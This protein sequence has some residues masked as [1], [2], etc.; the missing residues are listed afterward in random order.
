MVVEFVSIKNVKVYVL[1]V[2]EYIYVRIRNN[3]INALSALQKVAVN[4][5]NLL[6]FLVPVGNPTAFVATVYCIQM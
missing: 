5:A 6:E 3:E 4:I 1:N 2:M